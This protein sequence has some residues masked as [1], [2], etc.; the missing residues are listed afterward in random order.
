MMAK[1]L[2]ADEGYCVSIAMMGE[3]RERS[4]REESEY[5]ISRYT[6]SLNGDKRPRMGS[7]RDDHKG[8]SEREIVPGDD[9]VRSM[10]AIL[11]TALFVR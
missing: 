7:E 3:G 4:V 9:L 8:E 2:P 10:S 6:F 5:R 1:Q 11:C